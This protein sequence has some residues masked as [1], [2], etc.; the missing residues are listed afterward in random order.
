MRA[1]IV[2]LILLLAAPVE[3]SVWLAVFARNRDVTGSPAF[4]VNREPDGTYTKYPAFGDLSTCEGAGHTWYVEYAAM[5]RD[6]GD[7]VDISAEAFGGTQMCDSKPPAAGGYYACVEITDK[8]E[9]HARNYLKSKVDANLVDV[10][11]SRFIVDV[12]ALPAAIKDT[13]WNT[14]TLSR[15]WSQIKPFVIDKETGSPVP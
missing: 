2:A 13:L 4:C 9:A 5:R 8:D 15:T 6:R 3:A 1:L 10:Q 11:E 14:G 7:I 12:D